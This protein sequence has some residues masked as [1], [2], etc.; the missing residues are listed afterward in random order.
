MKFKPPWAAS[1]SCYL[2]SLVLT[3]ALAL[4]SAPGIVLLT[5]T[6]WL[7]SRPVPAADAL[8]VLCS[9]G[10]AAFGAWLVLLGLL[11][12]CWEALGGVS[13]EG[14]RLAATLRDYNDEEATQEAA[15]SVCRKTHE[16]REAAARSSLGHRLD[17]RLQ[18]VMDRLDEAANNVAGSEKGDLES[19]K[20]FHEVSRQLRVCG[21]AYAVLQERK[22]RPFVDAT[23]DACFPVNAAYALGKLVAFRRDLELS[24]RR[25]I[26]W[27]V[28]FAGIAASSIFLCF[29]PNVLF[30]KSTWNLAG[31]PWITENQVPAGVLQCYL[32]AVLLALVLAGVVAGREWNKALRLRREVANVLP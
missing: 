20:A 5:W 17:E 32:L 31:A 10:Q 3:A 24:T 12:S 8:A 25:M 27:L 28:L 7:H 11:A 1:R 29:D 13:Q 23:Y 26:S 18:S 16:L 30:L 19:L 4:F 15:R 22:V 2:S 14:S 9:F 6:P 21:G